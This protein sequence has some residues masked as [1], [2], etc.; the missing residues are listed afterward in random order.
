MNL[1]R[2]WTRN[3]LNLILRTS[4]N[5]CV[6]SFLKLSLVFGNILRVLDVVRWLKWRVISYKFMT[7]IL[8]WFLITAPLL[9]RTR[10]II[11]G[12]TFLL[13]LMIIEISRE[14]AILL[15]QIVLLAILFPSLAWRQFV[16]FCGPKFSVI[17]LF[18]LP[19][20][21]PVILQVYSVI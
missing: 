13:I 3:L 4:K 5:S 14:F 15:T 10:P 17:F 12:K 7:A 6:C 19:G 1:S 16:L 21:S 20:A 8:Y 2:I 18:I 9:R 11:E